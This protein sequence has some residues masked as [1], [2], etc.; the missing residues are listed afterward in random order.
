MVICHA[1]LKTLTGFYPELPILRLSLSL[2]EVVNTFRAW[3]RSSFYSFSNLA[4]ICTHDKCWVSLLEGGRMDEWM[5][6]G[7]H[8]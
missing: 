2:Q 6:T 4:Q 5:V 3:T 8:D 7:S 1:T